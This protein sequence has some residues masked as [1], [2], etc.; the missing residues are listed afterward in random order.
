M[1]E[2]VVPEPDYDRYSNRQLAAVPLAVLALALIVIA[3]WYV[4][5]G[6][7]VTLGLEFTGGTEIQVATDDSRGPGGGG[8]GR[9][10]DPD[11]LGGVR[12]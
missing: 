1:V 11:H 3:G 6:V 10:L 9:R 2:F 8:G 12:R 5:T 4:F 7:P